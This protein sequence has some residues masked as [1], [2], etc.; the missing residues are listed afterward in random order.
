MKNT[1]SKSPIDMYIKIVLLSLL[2]VWSFYIVKPFV[3]LIV[4][5]IILAV[6]LHPFYEK[7]LKITKGKKKGLVTSVFILILVALIIVPT[8]NLTGSIIDSGQELY[9]SFD[10]GTLKV[11]P[12]AERVKEWPLIGEKIYGV[13]SSA[14]SNLEDFI[15]KYKEEISNSLGWLFSS[16]AGLMGSVALG[17]FALIIAGVFM[18]SADAG[19]RSGVVFA[20]RLASGKGEEFMKMCVSTIRSVVKGILLVAIIQAGLA[21]LGFVIIGLPA[22]SLFA[23]LVLVFAIVQI[24]ALLA[25]I[26]AIAIVFSY[27][28]TTPA[29]IFTIYAII[30]AL[31]DNFLKPMLLGKGL[32][33]PMLVILIGALGGMMLQGILGLFIGPVV[34]ALMYQIYSNWVAEG[35]ADTSV[36]KITE[37]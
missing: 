33:T 24:P 28:E 26:P 32:A 15:V 12:P 18:S 35:T 22:A 9:Q 19:Y 30:V 13:W 20:N 25:M 29:I 31:S 37:E 14:S 34:L 4:W 36:E 11:P 21:Y 5:S 7:L 27:A 3:T 10:E 23:L 2:L 16:F 1:V 17:L 6:A 8:I